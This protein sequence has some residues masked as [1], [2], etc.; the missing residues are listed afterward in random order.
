M[1]GVGVPAREDPAAAPEA[2]R[3]E[4]RWLRSPR[5]LRGW[6]ADGG[7]GTGPVPG[8]SAAAARERPAPWPAQP[9]PQS[10]S[11]NCMRSSAASMKTYE[12]YRS[13]SWGRL[14]QVRPGQAEP[15]GAQLR[16]LWEEE[17]PPPSQTLPPFSPLLILRHAP[18][19]LAGSRR[20][21]SPCR[22]LA[23]SGMHLGVSS[24]S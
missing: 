23:C 8:I 5:C 16:Q 15:R 17:L 24:P 7:V 13:G 2:P 21:G 3:P 14:G 22:H 19:G 18:L 4:R 11:R 6:A 1:Q 9:P 12:G 10:I 20:A